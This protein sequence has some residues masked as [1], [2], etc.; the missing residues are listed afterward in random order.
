MAKVAHKGA[1]AGT[2]AQSR[3]CGLVH[4]QV[5]RGRAYNTPRSLIRQATVF[6]LMLLADPEI[7]AF[8]ALLDE[9]YHPRRFFSPAAPC[10]TRQRIP[11]FRSYKS[12]PLGKAGRRGWE[13]SRPIDAPCLGAFV[14]RFLA[15]QIFDPLIDFEQFP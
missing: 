9:V 4:A 14:F 13:I 8:C 10:R 2:V 5:L 6:L 3:S 11:V 12:T 1:N 15:D 7:F